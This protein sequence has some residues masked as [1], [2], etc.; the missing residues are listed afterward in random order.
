[1]S[2]LTATPV[3]GHGGAGR[4]CAINPGFALEEGYWGREIRIWMRLRLP[5]YFVDTSA[6]I[7]D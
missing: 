3:T 4:T 7:W 6:R 5:T 2:T 1:M